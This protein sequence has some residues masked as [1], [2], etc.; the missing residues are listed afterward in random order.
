MDKILERNRADSDGLLKQKQKL[1]QLLRVE[2]DDGGSDPE[3]FLPRPEGGECNAGSPALGT[4]SIDSSILVP[5]VKH[6]LDNIQ[7][8]ALDKLSWYSTFS[9]PWPW[10]WA[11][12]LPFS[13]PLLLTRHTPYPLLP[14]DPRVH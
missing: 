2:V 4:F 5:G 9:V 3:K 12:C 14:V 13:I 10:P 11:K 6:M 7:Q 8:L 1:A